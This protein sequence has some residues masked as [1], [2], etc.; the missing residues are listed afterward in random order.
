MVIDRPRT[1]L[2][3]T[4]S[5]Q[6]VSRHFDMVSYITSR[7]TRALRRTLESSLLL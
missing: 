2:N 1:D 6:T 7:I 5:R 3:L 4:I